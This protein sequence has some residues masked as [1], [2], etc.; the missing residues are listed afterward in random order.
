MNIFNIFSSKEEEVNKNDERKIHFSSDRL[1]LSPLSSICFHLEND[2]TCESILKNEN[3]IKKARDVCGNNYEKNFHFCI[4][5]IKNNNSELKL[6][7]KIKPKKLLGMSNDLKLFFLSNKEK[8]NN[9]EKNEIKKKVNINF[10]FYIKNIPVLI[11]DFEGNKYIKCNISLSYDILLINERKFVFLDFKNQI[12]EKIISNVKEKKK[13]NLEEPLKFQ[14]NVYDYHKKKN[15]IEVFKISDKGTRKQYDT[16][17]KWLEDIS[18]SK[19]FSKLNIS[20]MSESIKKN[21]ET[22]QTLIMKIFKSN[23]DLNYFLTKIKWSKILLNKKY[24]PNLKV[25]DIISIILEYKDSFQKKDMMNIWNV[26]KLLHRNINNLK[27]DNEISIF[28]KSKLNEILT[29]NNQVIEK[30]AKLQSNPNIK[31][32]ENVM[33]FEIFKID[34]FDF[35]LK[36]IL[37]SEDFSELKQRISQIGIKKNGI[38]LNK[39]TLDLNKIFASIYLN[40]YHFKLRD[41][42]L[43]KV[44]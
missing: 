29:L 38:Y 4:I 24:I 27:E 21:T 18:N 22:F 14:V 2:T 15:L 3:F 44:K 43:L 31:Q 35:L 17:I 23:L 10:D 1:N 41:F 5:D 36:P 19:N 42:I 20:K 37:E 28:L 33:L 34:Y 40:I 32:L 9:I 30:Y 6:S 13:F 26:F 12:D 8:K 25:P 11:W 39:I 7:N 16:L